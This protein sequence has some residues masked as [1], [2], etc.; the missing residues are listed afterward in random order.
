MRDP[1]TPAVR[2]IHR[3]ILSVGATGGVYKAR[4][5]Y[6]HELMTRAYSV[7]LVED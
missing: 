5:R 1:N 7:F 6:Q 2:I 3:I 4:G